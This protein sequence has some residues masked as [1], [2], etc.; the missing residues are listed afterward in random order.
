ML[1]I[2]KQLRRC[3]GK[4][5]PGVLWSRAEELQ[6][7]SKNNSTEVHGLKCLISATKQTLWRR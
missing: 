3:L 2:I 5:I 7:P 1:G 4:H 6:P